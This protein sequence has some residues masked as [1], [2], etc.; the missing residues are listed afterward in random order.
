MRR[1]RFGRVPSGPWSVRGPDTGAVGRACLV[2]RGLSV[3]LDMMIAG[4]LIAVVQPRLKRLLLGPEEQ[5][6][7]ER[8][9]SKAVTLTLA[10]LPLDLE[11]AGV[12]GERDTILRRVLDDGVVASAVVDD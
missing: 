9:M 5:R 2:G 10:E 4:R 1:P 11:E 7:V 8:A 3:A 6:A 12:A